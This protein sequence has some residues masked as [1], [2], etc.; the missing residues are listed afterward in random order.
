MTAF[1]FAISFILHIITICAIYLLFKQVQQMKLENPDEITSLMESYLQEIKDENNRLQ[2]ALSV[3]PVK[4]HDEQDHLHSETN[5]VN[6]EQ[7][8]STATSNETFTVPE[9][10]V[11]D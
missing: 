10:D 4:D 11:T 2:T 1:I 6:D 7:L 8:A 9:I 5:I 3:Q